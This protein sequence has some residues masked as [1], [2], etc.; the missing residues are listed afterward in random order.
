[1]KTAKSYKKISIISLLV[2]FVLCVSIAF[3]M[4]NG[5]QNVSATAN[6]TDF[7][8]LSDGVTAEFTEDDNLTF[9]VKNGSTIT[10]KN[11]LVISDMTW[12]FVSLP[13]N[14]TSTMKLKSDSYYVNGNKVVKVENEVEKISYETSI[15]NEIVISSDVLNIETDKGYISVNGTAETNTAKRIKDVNSMAVA[16]VSIEFKFNEGN[17]AETATFKLKS[18]N[19]KASDQT[20]DKF[21]QTFA[22][23]DN[24]KLTPAYPRVALNDSFYTKSTDGSYKAIKVKGEKQ[25]NMTLTPYSVLGGV[26]S[27]SLFLTGD[28]ADILLETGT[29]TPK[30]LL[31]RRSTETARVEKGDVNYEISFN[32]ST[33][34]SDDP[35]ETY[36]VEVKDDYDF[37]ADAPIYIADTIALEGFKAKLE[38]EYK[39]EDGKHVPMG[40]DLKIPS[41]EDLVYDDVTPYSE[42]KY[43][44]HLK[45]LTNDKTLSSMEIDL[46]EIGS[47]TFFITFTDKADNAI[48]SKDFVEEKDNE[49]VYGIYGKDNT[50]A[51]YVANFIF[52]FVM[53]DDADISVKAS[54]KSGVGYKGVQYSAAKFNVDANGCTMTYK[55]YYNEDKNAEK[56]SEGWKEIPKASSAT[57][58][59][60]VSKDGYTYDQIKEV[61]Y[62]GKLNFVPTK[63]GAYMIECVATSDVSSRNAEDFMIIKVEKAPSVVKVDNKWIQNNIW[64][65]VFLSIGTLCLIGIIVL[66]CI[67]PKD[68]VDND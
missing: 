50:V 57:K 9:T 30:K 54:V 24:Q 59:D 49:L 67:K 21:T 14:V 55:L 62:D 46:D 35:V 38:K 28:E 42:L 7:L 34:D 66:L 29:E 18:I 10:F 13:E 32:V 52:D 43:T 40:T 64:S 2:A 15:T 51:N 23:D 1:M 26:T 37:D 3:G 61:N 48:E 44:V 41:L 56:T 12:E 36:K 22:L 19:Q 6:A 39:E 65:V 16:T 68:D 33:K 45:T 17:T 60:Y 25:T 27:S 58:E 8:T 31:F 47:Y 20:P 4:L 53:Q 11:K 63:I 5:S